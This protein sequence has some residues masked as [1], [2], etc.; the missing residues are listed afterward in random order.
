MGVLAHDRRERLIE[1]WQVE[2]FDVHEF[3]LDVATICA[4]SQTHLAT[5][6]ACDR[7]CASDDYAISS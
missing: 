4:I 3:K 6:S 5:A 2:V 7:A 1:E